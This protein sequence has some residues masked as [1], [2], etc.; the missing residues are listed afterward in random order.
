MNVAVLGT[1]AKKAQQN[2]LSGFSYRK[3]FTVSRASGAVTDYQVKILVGESAGLTAGSNLVTNGGFD[4]ATTGWDTYQC[5]IASVAGG[6]TGNC[7]EITRTSGDI[8]SSGSVVSL[9]TGSRYR[10][11]V[12][13]K[14]GTSGNENGS[15]QVHGPGGDWDWSGTETFVSSGD[16][17]EHTLEF[18]AQ[19]DTGKVNVNKD[20]GTAG[21]MLF[22]TVTLY[23]IPHVD[24][25][26]HCLSTFNDLRFTTSDGST[27]LDYWIESITGTTP[28]QIATVWVECDSIGT[29]ATTFYLYYG[30]A[31]ASS[32]SSISDTFIFGDDFERGSNGDDVG[33]DWV[34][35]TGKVRI[36]TDQA[37]SGTRSA[38]LQG[39]S[40]WF[41]HVNAIAENVALR[42]RLWKANNTGAVLLQWGNAS[43]VS[44]LN[45][46]SSEDVNYD[47]GTL[48]AIYSG[49]LTG[50]W[51]LIEV[52]NVNLTEQKFDMYD[53]GVKKADQIGMASGAFGAVVFN[54]VDATETDYCYVDDVIIRNWRSVEPVIGS[55]GSEE[56][57]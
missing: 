44:K 12:Y 32:L 1:L 9:K 47:N 52:C 13:V 10:L 31:G 24:C 42:Y 11:S 40:N 38:R 34:Q 50:A 26:A 17:T 21:T 39:G 6:Q 16:W 41:Y 57:A 7:L 28:N 36:S 27:L 33:N 46:S 19:T 55:F 5:S 8:Q 54:N 45:I 18:V 56:A 22:D 35:D 23:E 25:N 49:F 37:F 29:E 43:Y 48:H 14:S 30:K 53:N 51:V 3:S 2:W 4:G 20:T 15:I